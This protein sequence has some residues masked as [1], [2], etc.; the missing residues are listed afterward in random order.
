[1]RQILVVDD[2]MV[3]L[4]Q[5]A[6]QLAGAYGF[7]LVKSGSEALDLCAREKPHLI[8]LDVNM[9]EMD[10][11]ETIARLKGNADTAGIPVIFLT[12]DNDTATEIRALESGAVDF[13]VK[14]VDKSILYH[15]IELHLQMHEYQTNL[16]SMKLALENSIVLSFADLIESKDSNTGGHVL[17][18]RNYMERL[19]RGILKRGLFRG[20]LT[21]ENLAPMV[22]GSPFHDIGKIGV[23]DVLLLKPGSLTPEEYSEIKQHTLIG[24]RVLER[25]AEYTSAQRYLEYAKEM[26]EGHHERYDGKGYP[27]GLRGEDIPLSCRIL[28]AANVFDACM[29]ERVYRK[30]LTREEAYGVILQGRGTEFDPDVVDAFADVFAGDG[31]RG[32][33]EK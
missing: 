13:I 23:S 27:H 18:T 2:N 12:G 21:E 32:V 25:I 1:M 17:R 11:F 26:A 19:G 31:E 33:S 7:S 6:A 4:K 28:A 10:G 14:P 3:S 8:L 5:V 20:V 16:E 29:T 15:R 30:A 9:P 22:Q 24:A